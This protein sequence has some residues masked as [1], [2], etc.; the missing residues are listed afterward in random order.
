MKNAG[1]GS[2]V[3]FVN[4]SID[5]IACQ[6]RPLNILRLVSGVAGRGCYSISPVFLGGA[7]YHV[8]KTKPLFEAQKEAVCIVNMVRGIEV[9]SRSS[10]PGNIFP[11]WAFNNLARDGISVV[12]VPQATERKKL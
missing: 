7:S 10:E 9:W 12:P 4:L 1:L 2:K 6:T 5:V 3:E 8:K 11:T